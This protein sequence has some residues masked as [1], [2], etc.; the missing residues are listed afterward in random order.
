M[1]K[2]KKITKLMQSGLKR[3]P[4]S[5]RDNFP[6]EIVQK[7]DEV[8]EE[9]LTNN[10]LLDKKELWL[11]KYTWKG[12]QFREANWEKR[13]RAIKK[14]N[15]A[16]KEGCRL[17]DVTEEEIDEEIGGINRLVLKKEGEVNFETFKKRVRESKERSKS[18]K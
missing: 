18:K 16:I 3:V 15:L 6:R 5:L 14:I 7:M 11:I 8:I 10:K 17:L 12:I 4:G 2:K 1:A 13:V 9:I